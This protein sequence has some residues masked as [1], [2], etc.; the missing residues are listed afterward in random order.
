MCTF[1]KS[2]F[3]VFH[4]Y[5]KIMQMLPRQYWIQALRRSAVFAVTGDAGL[6]FVFDRC[7][8]VVLQLLLLPITT[9]SRKNKNDNHSIKTEHSYDL[10]TCPLSC[11]TFTE[12]I[13]NTNKNDRHEGGRHEIK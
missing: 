6:E 2:G 12:F 10:S 8:F 3:E 9:R 5:V 1:T 13:A 4:L 7:V 11:R